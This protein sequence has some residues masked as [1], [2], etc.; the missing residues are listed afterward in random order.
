FDRK[1]FTTLHSFP[2]KSS[3]V[4]R[5]VI[6]NWQNNVIVSNF[7]ETYIVDSSFSLIHRL[8]NYQNEPLAG[9]AVIKSIAKDNFG[10]LYLLTISNGFVKAIANNYPIR[11]YGAAGVENNF[12]I[13]LLA[14][15]KNNRIIAG[16]NGN[17][18]L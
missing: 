6:Y 12:V 9:N 14:D 8:V 11:Y 1:E 4:F 7:N 3:K 17:G 15:K 18:I 2:Y 16:T 10:N 5:S 13:G